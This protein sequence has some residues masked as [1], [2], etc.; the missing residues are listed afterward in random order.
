MKIESDTRGPVSVS[1]TDGNVN[2]TVRCPICEG[3]HPIKLDRRGN[4]F[5]TLSCVGAGSNVFPRTSFGKEKFGEWKEAASGCTSPVSLSVPVA[6]APAERVPSGSAPDVEPSSA[7][8]KTA[9]REFL[10]KKERSPS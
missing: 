1:V 10:E 4:P 8:L 9:L 6:E 5:V 7:S 2:D 3:L